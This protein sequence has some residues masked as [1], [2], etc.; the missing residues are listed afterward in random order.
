MYS[1]GYAGMRDFNFKREFP[2]Y[3][4]GGESKVL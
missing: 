3:E 2:V 4:E 1:S